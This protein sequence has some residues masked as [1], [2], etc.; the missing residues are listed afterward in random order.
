MVHSKRTST[1]ESSTSPLMQPLAS[2]FM[3][4]I[5]ASTLLPWRP[6]HLAHVS[7]DGAPGSMAHG[8]SGL[9]TQPSLPLWTHSPSFANCPPLTPATASYSS[10]TQKYHPTSP[11]KA[12]PLCHGRTSPNLHMTSSIIVLNSLT[13]A[14]ES[15]EPGHTISLNRE[16][17]VSMSRESC[18]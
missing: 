7:L 3:K 18:A 5:S 9:T 1:C 4:R 11:R 16:Q 14:S 8:L 15:S 17:F 13:K 10:P 6:A 12:S 2:I